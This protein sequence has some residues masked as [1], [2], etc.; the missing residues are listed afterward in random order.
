MTTQGIVNLEK[1]EKEWGS[2]AFEK[3]IDNP[4]AG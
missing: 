2:E 3:K 1:M 4:Q